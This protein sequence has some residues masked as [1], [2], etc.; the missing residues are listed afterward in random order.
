ML[1]RIQK[2]LAIVVENLDQKCMINQ[3]KAYNYLN[4]AF[5][6]RPSS[7]GW[8]RMD[9]PMSSRSMK[10]RDKCMGINFSLGRVKC[11]RTGY[12]SS[13]SDFLR[14]ITQ[15]DTKEL[16]DLLSNFT[17]VK[18]N[19]T[20]PLNYVNKS[21]S[22]P[23]DFHLIDEDSMFSDRVKSYLVS[24]GI[25]VEFA[26][27]RSIGYCLKGDFALRIVIPFMNPYLE[28]YVGR[29][30]VNQTPK[31]RNPSVDDIGVRKSDVLYN[32]EALRTDK[33]YITEGIF[34]ALTCGY[35]GV[36][37]LG[38]SLS[39]QQLSKLI[40]AKADLYIVPDKGF[41]AKALITAKKLIDH[42]TVYIT[43][44]DHIQGNDINDLGTLD[45]LTFKQVSWSTM[46]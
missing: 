15:K 2:G 16:K 27:S 5:E 18:F 28:Y 21:I 4:S 32:E 39:Q 37:T 25:D 24:R 38:W 42:K 19:I 44:L 22:L 7:N 36:A 33:A 9:N 12:K 34:D 20:I 26:K 46:N 14:I 6:L 17:E 23:E 35:Q 29:S 1:L 40:N 31:Y 10:I 43:N 45:N 3:G 8:Y 13:V 11:H 30:I 41:Y